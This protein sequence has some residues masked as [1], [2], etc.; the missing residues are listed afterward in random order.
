MY[1]YWAA[2]PEPAPPS[3][4]AGARSRRAER[5]PGRGGSGINLFHEALRT[6]HYMNIWEH[7]NKIGANITYCPPGR[8]GG[9]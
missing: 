7:Y 3:R 2:G 1:M 6:T 9:E 8:G 4:S 5:R